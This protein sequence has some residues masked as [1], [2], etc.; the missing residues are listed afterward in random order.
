MS[1]YYSPYDPIFYA[2]EALIL[3]ENALGMAGRIHRGFDAERRSVELGSTIEIRKPSVLTSQA[4][5]TGT[6]QEINTQK[7]TISLNNWR[8]VKFGLTDKELAYTSDRIISEHISPGVYAL[9]N[10]IETQITGLYKYI[11]YSYDLAGTPEPADTV[12]AR[13]VMR[14]TAGSILEDQMLHFAIDST[15][16]AGYLNSTLFHAANVA[17]QDSELARMRGHLGVRFGVEHFVQQTLGSH[18]GGTVTA[19]A[20]AVGAAADTAIRSTTLEVSGVTADSTIKAGDS[21][22]IAGDTLPSGA[23]RRYV[24]TADATFTLGTAT[25][26]IYPA[27][28]KA[29]TDSAAPAVTFET[30]GTTAGSENY[31]D[32]HRYSIMFHR[33]AFALAM[34]PLPMIGDGAGARMAS[35][36]DPRTGLA[37][38]SR[39]AYDD[40]NAKV[41]VTLD[42]LF[43]VKT[44]DPNLAVIVRRDA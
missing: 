12:N 40:T 26:S 1:N 27:L 24:A 43:G 30:A 21:F 20:D 18:T 14:D 4:G 23:L 32:A 16:E 25:L 10:Y 7:E 8:E 33:N 11:P 34:A 3:L 2:Q 41:I 17:G 19:A 36:L 29:I 44:L 42:V 37:M 9:A 6:A 39:L 28:Q 31:S 13:K 35:I 22:T 15:I 5:G 38:R